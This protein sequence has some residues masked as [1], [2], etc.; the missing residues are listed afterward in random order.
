MLCPFSPGCLGIL[1][2]GEGDKA[3]LFDLPLGE[4]VNLFTKRVNG[5]KQMGYEGTLGRRRRRGGADKR[6]LFRPGTRTW[7]LCSQTQSNLVLIFNGDK[8]G[9]SSDK[10]VGGGDQPFCWANCS[11]GTG[12]QK[13]NENRNNPNASRKTGN[14]V[15]HGRK[16]WQ[17]CLEIVQV[18]CLP[19][20]SRIQASTTM[21]SPL[22]HAYA[23]S[24]FLAS[25]ENKKM[26]EEEEDEEVI[27]TQSNLHPM[28]S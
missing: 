24:A 12:P 18:A 26:E 2:G 27:N 28:S 7:S 25:E 19:Q 1:G 5:M 14:E 20:Q 17:N 6:D 22:R 11:E 3:I 13:K 23:Q 16:F 10:G 8:E 15:Q 4:K 9:W 21:G